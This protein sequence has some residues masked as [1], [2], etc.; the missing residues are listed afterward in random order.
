MCPA[1]PCSGSRR[2]VRSPHLRPRGGPPRAG[3]ARGSGARRRSRARAADG[4][5]AGAIPVPRPTWPCI[6]WA[7]PRWRVVNGSIEESHRCARPA[8]PPRG[9]ARAPAGRCRSALRA[10]PRARSIW[11]WRRCSFRCARH[12]QAPFEALRRLAG[13]PIHRSRPPFCVQREVGDREAGD[14]QS[15]LQ[16]PAGELERLLGRAQRLG[17]PAPVESDVAAVEP[18][19]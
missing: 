11:H 15:E 16:I 17:H 14:V 1:R 7:Q 19:A 6:S 2:S 8:R 10:R 13:R 5:R 3:P 12:L 4:P 9:S 18:G